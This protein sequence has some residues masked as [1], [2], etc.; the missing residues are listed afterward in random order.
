MDLHASGCQEF[1]NGSAGMAVF[2][3]ARRI[4][5]LA[6]IGGGPPIVLAVVA[7]RFGMWDGA[8]GAVVVLAI[9]IWIGASASSWKAAK[10][11]RRR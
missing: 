3:N 4:A 5:R 9:G 8:V 7:S 1:P 2:Q 6:V 11:H 10:R